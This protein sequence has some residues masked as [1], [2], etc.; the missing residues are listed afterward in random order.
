MELSSDDDYKP[1]E[2]KRPLKLVDETIVLDSDDDSDRP[3]EIIKEKQS[4]VANT[5][6]DFVMKSFEAISIRNKPNVRD[7]MPKKD[8][9]LEESFLPLSQRMKKKFNI[10]T[11]SVFDK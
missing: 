11:T 3:I 5:D 10:S 7:K 6:F 1:K 9:Q 4:A 2:N 8:I